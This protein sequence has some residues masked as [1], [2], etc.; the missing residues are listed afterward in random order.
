LTV[1]NY[2]QAAKVAIDYLT[3]RPEVDTEAIGASGYSMGSYWAMRLAAADRR[4]RA[5]ATAAS[6]YGPMRAIFEE[7][8]PRFKQVFMYM[9]G[10][11][12]EDEFDRM[13][14]GMNLDKLASQ[15]EGR[16]LMVV[17][18][19]DPLD[20]LEDAIAVFEKVGGPK[21]MW[22]VEDQFHMPAFTDNLGGTDVFGWLADWLR[23]A[24]AGKSIGATSR[25]VLVPRA[26]G[27]GPYTDPTTLVDL[28]LPGRLGESIRGLTPAQ[29]GIANDGSAADAA[30]H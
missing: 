12:D 21:E 30:E 28:Y 20:H 15:I 3:S 2:E 13:A 16:T 29:I 19:Y 10:I 9:A 14:A 1:D 18:E 5:V 8:S 25:V 6:A 24:L 27:A 4:V 23:D 11:H 26:T 22:I 7:A 17:G